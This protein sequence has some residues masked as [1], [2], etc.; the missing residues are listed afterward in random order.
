MK[1][2]QIC[3][4]SNFFTNCFACLTL[5]LLL[6]VERAELP[7]NKLILW[8]NVF[9]INLT[10]LHLFCVS[11]VLSKNTK[12]TYVVFPNEWLKLHLINVEKSDRI[13]SQFSIIIV[14]ESESYN[15]SS[16]SRS[17]YL[18]IFLPNKIEKKLT[19]NIWSFSFDLS[20]IVSRCSLD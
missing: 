3:V 7:I 15:K 9:P 20:I 19:L 12:W 11:L 10:P 5:I 1:R 2:R 8:W 6:N 18:Y 13:E 17:F 4:A 16:R 14:K